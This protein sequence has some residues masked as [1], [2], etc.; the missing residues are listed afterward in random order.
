MDD[1]IAVKTDPAAGQAAVAEDSEAKIAALEAENAKLMEE[2]ENYRIGM[3]KAKANAK[4][5]PE[6]D[7]ERV[8]LIARQ[9]IAD[10]RLVE[11][12][13]EKQAIIDRTIKE[14]KELKLA[15]LNKN[16]PAAGVGSHSESSPVQDTS[17][18]P[19]QLEA[20]KRR[21]W[22]EKDIERYKKNL[23]RYSGR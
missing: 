8:T 10:S 5:N 13:K 20:F 17:I 19:E 6:D 22:T 15:V 21:G 23:K 12:A 3:L 4:E 18:T 9:A 7:D 2:R 16:Q 14:N 1:K 11:I